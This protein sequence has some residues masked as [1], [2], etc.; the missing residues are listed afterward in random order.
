MNVLYMKCLKI[1]NKK[2]YKLI[3]FEDGDFTLDVNVSPKDDIVWLNR[4]ELSLL[5]DRDIKPIRKHI[6]NIL[7][8]KI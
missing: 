5:F 3:K 7:K 4:I 1:I 8:E 2:K 6:N